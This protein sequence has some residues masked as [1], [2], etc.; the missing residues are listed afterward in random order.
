[1][2]D[3]LHRLLDDTRV[4]REEYPRCIIV[5]K[6]NARGGWDGSVEQ[7]LSELPSEVDVMTMA[8]IMREAGDF[9]AQQKQ[10]GESK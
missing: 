1:M 6:P 8:R 5:F 4:L 3:K 9:F 7:W 10:K 2:N